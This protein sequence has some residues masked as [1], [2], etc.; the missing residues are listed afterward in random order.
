[1]KAIIP[2]PTDLN[3]E[4]FSGASIERLSS[5]IENGVIEEYPEKKRYVTQRPSF[6]TVV[7]ASDAAV[8]AKGRGVYF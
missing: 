8:P 4:K 6:T 7:D 5:Y 3:I 1:M 2:I